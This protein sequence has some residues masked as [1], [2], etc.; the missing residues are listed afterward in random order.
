MVTIIDYGRGPQIEGTRITVYDVLHYHLAGWHP[1]TIAG[2]FRLSSAQIQAALDYGEANREEVMREN[3]KIEE[4]IARGNPPEVQAKLDAIHA[5]YNILWEDKLKRA[6]L[7]EAM[8]EGNSTG[9]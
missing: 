2:N 1:T 5:K 8:H 3:Q 9:P 7:W 4:R 6:G